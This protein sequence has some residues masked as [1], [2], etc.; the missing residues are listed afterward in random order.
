MKTTKLVIGIISI[1]LFGIILL[2]SCAAGI[3]NVAEKNTADTTAAAG[4]FVGFSMLIAGIV[5]IA[6]RNSKGGG[7]T[8][9]V[10]Y[11]AAALIGFTNIGTYKDLI[12]WSVLS[13]A[14]G[15]IYIIGSITRTKE[16]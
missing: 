4:L 15:I 5:G 10:F 2:Q 6:T 11:L 12:I 14:F 7:I 1:V 3:V 9:G 13:A 8:S 16:S